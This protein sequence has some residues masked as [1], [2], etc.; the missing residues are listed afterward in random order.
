RFAYVTNSKSDN[1]SMYTVDDQTGQLAQNGVV[2]AGAGPSWITTDPSN[3][4]AYVTNGGGT[5]VSQYTIARDGK[6]T[7]MIQPTAPPRSPPRPP[8]R[9]CPR[10]VCA[11]PCL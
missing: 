9:E 6:L 1:V 5:T 3:K 11:A 4:Y 8:P 10:A 2:A 7:P